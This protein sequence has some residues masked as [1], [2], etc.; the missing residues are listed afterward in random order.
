M[1]WS[2]IACSPGW[3][4]RVVWGRNEYDLLIVAVSPGAIVRVAILKT[5][6]R[7]APAG[8]AEV[9]AEVDG[10][11]CGLRPGVRDVRGEVDV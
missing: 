10:G 11:P 6:G 7:S 4:V 2:S 8:F 5:L 9:Q 3:K 1:I